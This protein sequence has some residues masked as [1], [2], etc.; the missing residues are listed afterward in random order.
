MAIARSWHAQK[1]SS[2]EQV[3]ATLLAMFK[4]IEQLRGSMV[5]FMLVEK[6]D[7]VLGT[8]RVACSSPEIQRCT[9]L[10]EAERD[11]AKE[12]S[13]RVG[14]TKCLCVVAFPISEDPDAV[15]QQLSEEVLHSF[16][17]EPNLN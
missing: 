8:F 7:I 15:A 13:E 5:T 9:K 6:S 3:R 10:F 4:Q 14:P 11:L 17:L 2:V 12:L 1:W 16:V